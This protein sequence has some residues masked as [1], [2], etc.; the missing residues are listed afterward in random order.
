MTG[1]FP[2]IKI[3]RDS[4]FLASL[5]FYNSKRSQPQK[6]GSWYRCFIETHE[7]FECLKGI[8]ICTAQLGSWVWVWTV[9]SMYLSPA[10]SKQKNAK[11]QSK[12]QCLGCAWSGGNGQL[13]CWRRSK[14]WVADFPSTLRGA[15]CSLSAAYPLFLFILCASVE[16]QALPMAQLPTLYLMFCFCGSYSKVLQTV[17]I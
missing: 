6:R 7:I 13:R 12:Q 4:L 3:S 10:Q 2:R 1:C 17:G 5:L 8:C 16:K 15:V 14:R 9:C 11:S